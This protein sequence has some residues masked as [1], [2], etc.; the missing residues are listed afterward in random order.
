M[1]RQLLQQGLDARAIA[2]SLWRRLGDQSLYSW[3]PNTDAILTLPDLLLCRGSE[4]VLD[5]FIQTLR[6]CVKRYLEGEDEPK[7]SSLDLI[8]SLHMDDA[9]ARQVGLLFEVEPNLY[10][11]LSHTMMGWEMSVANQVFDLR[12]VHTIDDYLAVRWRPPQPSPFTDV[13]HWQAPQPV[14]APLPAERAAPSRDVFVVHGHDE[15]AREATARFIAQLGLHPII[16]HEQANQG[17][18]IIEKFEKHAQ[19][20][21]AVV[22][23]TPDD[24]GG[25]SNE[26]DALKPRAR[27]NVILELGY[28]LGRL[29]RDHVCALYKGGVELPSDMSGVLYVPMDDAGAWKSTLSREI[30]AAGLDINTVS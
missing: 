17:L 1:E 4:P 26:Q 18:T 10:T 24:T 7:V 11:T 3:D 6:L 8:A 23:L 15:A 20:A 25:S 30:K 2:R 12:N 27:Q 9:L 21:F 16:L 22:L 14:Q 13:P 29:G 5:A 28:F 19:V